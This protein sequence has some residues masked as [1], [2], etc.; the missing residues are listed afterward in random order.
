[1]TNLDWKYLKTLCRI[2]YNSN[3]NIEQLKC[4]LDK[5]KDKG[6]IAFAWY[7]DIP[8]AEG[9]YLET[10]TDMIEMFSGCDKVY[11]DQMGEDNILLVMNKIRTENGTPHFR[12][13][14]SK[15]VGRYYTCP[16]KRSLFWSK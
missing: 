5:F 12:V 8:I 2:S 6:Y 13:C 1:M 14:Q 16:K 15:I 11:A 10:N 9:V 4:L 3:R 7:K